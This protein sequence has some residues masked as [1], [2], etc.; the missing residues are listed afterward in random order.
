MVFP[1]RHVDKHEFWMVK[2]TDR[3]LNEIH[4]LYVYGTETCIYKT[5]SAKTNCSDLNVRV[6]NSTQ[7]NPLISLLV[8][9]SIKSIRRHR[10]RSHPSSRQDITSDLI[11]HHVQAIINPYTA[12]S[13]ERIGCVPVLAGIHY[14]LPL[15]YAST[16]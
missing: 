9:Y 6:T 5:Y 7:Q 4:R 10:R 3:N 15:L 11:L 16:P 14:Q 2:H 12:S 8:K 1:G 13:K